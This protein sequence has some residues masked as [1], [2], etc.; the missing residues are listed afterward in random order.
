MELRWHSLSSG[1]VPNILRPSP[2]CEIKRIR[3]YSWKWVNIYILENQNAETHFKI[4]FIETNEFCQEIYIMKK[5]NA[6][7]FKQ[8]EL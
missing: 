6:H 1:K 4:I 3:Q 7:A 2:E 8:M 5:C